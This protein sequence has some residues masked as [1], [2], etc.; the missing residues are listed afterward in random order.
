MNGDV[1]RLD[2]YPLLD[3]RCEVYRGS[4]FSNAYRLRTVRQPAA[5]D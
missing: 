3:D 1:L 4:E 2:A 5:P